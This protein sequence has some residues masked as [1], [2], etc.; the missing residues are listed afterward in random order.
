MKGHVPPYT[1]IHA[2]PLLVCK[3]Y[4]I[5]VLGIFYPFSLSDVSCLSQILGVDFAPLFY[6]MNVGL[7]LLSSTVFKDKFVE[8]LKLC[9]NYE[10]KNKQNMIKQLGTGQASEP[11]QKNSDWRG[12]YID[13]SSPEKIYSFSF[14]ICSPPLPFFCCIR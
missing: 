9:N 14:F 12:T 6:A 4:W 8:E 5:L 13:S 7:L 1:S 3:F 11:K 2:F 10:Y